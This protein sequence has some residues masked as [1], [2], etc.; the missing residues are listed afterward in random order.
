MA[1]NHDYVALDWVKGEIET[2]LK[3]AQV[4]LEDYVNNPLDSTRLRFCLN[5]I[6]QVHGTLQMVEFYGAALL[7]EEMEQL[8]QALLAGNL[9]Q[10]E[11]AIEVLMR[12][13]L[14]L[15]NYLGL[16]QANKEDQPVILLPILNDLRASRGADLL[17][18]TSM[19]T[20]DLS[21]IKGTADPQIVARLKDPKAIRQL[22]R[23]RQ[24]YQFSLAG[25]VREHELD[26][27]LS[28]LS[29]VCERLQDLCKDSSFEQ[30]WRLGYAFIEGLQAKEI[31]LSSATKNILRSLDHS[32]KR[33]IDECTDILGKSAPEDVTKHILYYI[34]RSASD[35]PRLNSI[36][37]EYRLDLALP[38]DSA[39]KSE[40]QRLSGPD[41]GAIE[42]VVEA[43]NEEL[44]R[45]K[46]Q[47]DLF[48]R[49]EVKDLNDLGDLRPALQQV[50]NTMAVLGVGL[51]RKV[52]EEQIV[53]IDQLVAQAELPEDEI[54]MEIAGALLY[55]EA[56]L[57]GYGNET[58][59]AESASQHGATFIMPKEQIDNAHEA[60][61]RE[62]RNGLEQAKTDI[63]E[64][65]ASQFDKAEIQDV[66]ARLQSIRG[67]LQIIPLD[68]AA[69]LLNNCSRFISEQLLQ[70]QTAPDW[71]Q[72]DT[73]A[74]A[75]T[76]I[77]YY[78]E[79]LTEGSRDND[80]ILEVAE[81]SLAQ[82]GYSDKPEAELTSAHARSM[83]TQ[84]EATTAE[85]P[86][87]SHQKATDEDLI[88]ADI[89]EIF[90]EEAAE[91]LQT[92]Q[93][94]YPAFHGQTDDAHA[95]TELR[96]SYHTLKGSGRLVGATSIGELCWAV[97]NLLNRVIDGS[98]TA[99][100]QVFELLEAV[101]AK[102]PE[103]IDAYQQGNPVS[104]DIAQYVA[105]AEQ[106][107]AARKQTR[108]ASNPGDQSGH[109]AS[110]ITADSAAEQD[111]T[112][113]DFAQDET[114]VTIDSA[115]IPAVAPPAATLAADSESTDNKHD[116]ATDNELIDEEII[117]IFAEEAAD[118]QELLHQHLPDYLASYN[119]LDA[120]SEVRRSFHTLKGSGRLVGATVL[121]ELAWS[122]ENLLNR[123]IDGNI[124]MSA[125][126][127]ALLE[128]VVSLLPDLVADFEQQRPASHDVQPLQQTA[129]ALANGDAEKVPAGGDTDPASLAN[130]EA[131]EI[132]D[133]MAIDPVL[134]DIFKT[135]TLCHLETLDQ[136]ITNAKAPGGTATITDELSRAMHT[137]KGS[138]N[139]AGISPIA[140]IAIPAESFIKEIRARNIPADQSI[141]DML[142]SFS[143]FIRAG[144]AQ[145]ESDPQGPI[146]GAGNFPEQI[147]ALSNRLLPDNDPHTSADKQAESHLIELFLTESIDVLL[148]A[149]R[150]LAD[151]NANHQHT[152]EI[153][154]LAGE[155]RGLA[156]GATSAGLNDVADLS[157]AMEALYQSAMV[158]QP[159]SD[160]FFE[161][162][163]KGQEALISIMDQLAAGLAA[164]YQ[165]QLLAEIKQASAD[166]NAQATGPNAPAKEEPDDT[167]TQQQPPAFADID[168]DLLEVF[169]E[170][171]GELLNNSADTLQQWLD[172]HTNFDWVRALQQDLHTLKGGARL[173]GI[174]PIGDLSHELE[175]MFEAILDEQLTV[176]EEACNL[177][178]LAHEALA[179]MVEA[180]GHSGSCKD[181]PELVK[182]LQGY[183]TNDLVAGQTGS[184]V[185]QSGPNTG[186]I[187]GDE[188]TDTA[189]SYADEILHAGEAGL[190]PEM[191]EIFLGEAREIIQRSSETLQAWCD[192][193]RDVTHVEQLQRDLHTLKGG[194]RM[195]EIK[196]IGD[197][198]HQLE[199]LFEGVH[200]GRLFVSESM[201]DLVTEAHDRLAIMIE[202]VAQNLPIPAASG[203]IER[204]QKLASAACSPAAEISE[205]QELAAAS[206]YTDIATN[207][208]VNESYD[209]HNLD[210][211]LVALFLEEAE[212]LIDATAN[213]LQ[214][215]LEDLA[216]LAEVKT[217]QRTLH[218]LKG[219]ARL[220]E[221]KPIGDLA[222]ELENLFEGI[223][224]DRFSASKSLS[225]LLLQCH[226]RLAEM[227]EGVAAGQ[228]VV[229]ANDLIL[230]INHYCQH[231][232]GQPGS[233]APADGQLTQAAVAGQT[234]ADELRTIFV[235]EARDIMATSG[236]YFEAWKSSPEDFACAQRLGQEISTL[237]AGAKLASANSVSALAAALSRR[238]ESVVATQQQ[239]STEVIDTVDRAIKYLKRLLDQIA[240]LEQ[241]DVPSELI[242]ELDRSGA[243]QRAPEANLHIDTDPEI[244]QVFVEEA[245]DLQADL[246]NRLADWEKDPGNSVHSE[247]IARA[248]HTLKGGA[249]LANLSTI[250][251]LAQE[252]E[253]VIKTVNDQQSELNAELRG[254]INP[255]FT[256]LKAELT[257]INN[258]Y[259][260]LTSVGQPAAGKHAV[261]ATTDSHT[262]RLL[263]AQ[264]SAAESSKQQAK[265]ASQPVP[266]KSQQSGRQA[267]VEN[268]RVP[269]PLLDDLVNLAGETSIT[270][271]LLEQKIS[272]FTFTLEEMQT[273]IDRLREQLRRMDM[274]TEA[275][276]LFSLEKEGG[277]ENEDF[278]P[279]ELDRYSSI[280]QL[281]R[282]LSESAF[283]LTDLR[284][285]MLNKAKDADTL[286]LQQSRINTELQEGL[287]KTR[288]IPF[289]SIVPRLRRIV[290]QICS[291]LG[292]KVDF[293]VYN[294]E[295]ELDRNVLERMV[296][297]LEHML[298]NAIGHGIELPQDRV[299]AGKSPTGIIELAVA[300][301]GGDVV[302]TLADDGAGIDI[303]AVRKKAI[304]Q[305]LIDSKTAT[306]DHDVLQYIFHAGFS[307]A[308]NVTQISGRGV[309]MDVVSSEI[310]QLSGRVS[311]DSRKGRGTRFEVHLPFTVSVNRAL[312]VNTGEDY[313]AIPLNSI[314][315]IV[316]VSAYELEEYYKPNSPFFEYAGQSYQLQYLG[317]LLKSGHYPK[318]HGQPLPLP[319]ILVRGGDRPLALQV[320]SLMG[321]RE[322]VVKT[323]GAQFSEVR[324]V[325]GATILGDGNVVV[326]LDLPAMIRS[327]FSATIAQDEQATGHSKEGKNIS[328]KVMVVDDSVTVRKV[329]S[330]LLERNGMEVLLAKDGVDAIALLQ[331]HQPDIML[332]D[333]EMPRM[334]GFEVASL[335]RHDARLKNVP[336]I[337]I[338]SRTGQKH[339]ERATAIGVNEYLGKPFQEGQLLE[340]I[341]RLVE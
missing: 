305:G 242:G 328:T 286:L 121:G 249:R 148:D 25:V 265:T 94:C 3:Q 278:D 317:T 204:M 93:T 299:K 185:K 294:P 196:P 209:L 218:T 167:Q 111:D 149:E 96:R 282:A 292:K 14:Q 36:R 113:A 10:T 120:L 135:E 46:D 8:T 85:A 57:S 48:V 71:G 280:Q 32:I 289:T 60:V 266:A 86:A 87:T 6:H 314:E 270:R 203:L 259:Q 134:R 24:M 139:T 140:A 296:A 263:Q 158:T 187:R 229:A 151:W 155:L 279:L 297:P 211:E 119:N 212:E 66:P 22:R 315:G 227:I 173:A 157:A 301:E 323:L 277:L 100:V 188:E 290:R 54:F 246:E 126:A 256:H 74:D 284:E 237:T 130:T 273:T 56:S 217:L 260:T 325:S 15:P 181:T 283:D 116:A 165:H 250:G 78:L 320:D 327:D 51:P 219:G 124:S 47:L 13:I 340:T 77:E 69:A 306:S 70:Q 171:A 269:A 231:H 333:I 186:N 262:E 300:R 91:V 143:G 226:D 131:A 257:K 198:S 23:L 18:D 234:N 201:T 37:M 29:K 285:T 207:D 75:I 241:P 271:G 146:E 261:K 236:G 132:A 65:I 26:S 216:N 230:R 82:L 107:A 104:S 21:K 247:E 62:A 80:M 147:T 117:E 137:L 38:A 64:Y 105:T 267:P 252:F 321:S 245:A 92:I 264:R 123:V 310:K 190:D 223:V 150:I 2:T 214:M 316:R 20:P 90:V 337:M 76:S 160:S 298:R 193:S 295:G 232:S 138:A 322:I 180:I 281:S 59:K 319:V 63:V 238:M 136:F 7:A 161:L 30:L 45:V 293:K 197:L 208:V 44:A 191:A 272:D 41:R 302:L 145:I 248:L 125:E 118:V 163:G 103:L 156:I 49:S 189:A 308:K 159:V 122:V 79:R 339:R 311:I 291:E 326:I 341:T 178:M 33:L 1:D 52:I 318:L 11:E 162:A 183:I 224:E 324:G 303:D 73:L 112:V 182:A 61:I 53:I 275:Q 221:I 88:D 142:T 17:S 192:D 200:E 288:M 144:I 5:Y 312:M 254:E 332:L 81:L 169:L 313:Y 175:N 179:G 43:L 258:Y 309:G 114:V 220:A 195:A 141:I 255:L 152:D 307:T 287:M 233:S 213:N 133:E 16:L 199:T 228:P 129:N 268:I 235:E 84:T 35:N 110:D 102:L 4:A 98:V 108:A 194:A 115:D 95:L 40:Q 153:D 210:P 239:V 55:V 176:S 50:A 166:L 225:T 83:A 251:D 58:G 329:T 42:S 31:D 101:N 240:E 253:S 334:D 331:D 174:A 34:A 12:A 128:R 27:N 67:G 164:D 335:V 244:L 184:E 89:I 28:Y 202:N 274:E 177:T 99:N 215:W 39:V 109:T 330:R 243:D 336:I 9:P 72:L 170:E 127:G 338:T 168:A 222:H 97:E 304:S 154:K 19:F 276:I 205:R 172:D 106:L 68:S 206:S